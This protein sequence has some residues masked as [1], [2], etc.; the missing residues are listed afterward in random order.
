MFRSL[1][2]PLLIVGG[3]LLFEFDMIER[4]V[5]DTVFSVAVAFIL[6]STLSRLGFGTAR[7]NAVAIALAAVSIGAVFALPGVALTPYLAVALI[8]G[9]IA[10]VFACGLLPGRTSVIT[11]IIRLTG[12]GPDGSA[13]FQR[14]AH[15]QCWIWAVLAAVTATLGT[16]AMILAQ[17]REELGT[18]IAIMLVFQ[19]VWFV[20]THVYAQTR[21]GRPESCFDTIRAMADPNAWSKIEL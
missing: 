7:A 16:A 5:L 6:R 1:A 11:Q 9:V 2:P 19:A 3:L 17:W 10:Y 13:A 15:G 8:N 14:Y 12:M 21:Y 4:W 18:A 20:A